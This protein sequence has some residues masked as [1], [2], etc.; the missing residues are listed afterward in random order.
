[1]S[2]AEQFVRGAIER[3]WGYGATVETKPLDGGTGMIKVVGPCWGL[4]CHAFWMPGTAYPVEAD[5]WIELA[6]R[7]KR[8]AVDRRVNL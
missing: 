8:A 4:V 7:V 5:A 1:M 6:E 2:E 3:V